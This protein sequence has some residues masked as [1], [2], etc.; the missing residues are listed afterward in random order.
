MS[1]GVAFEKEIKRLGKLDSKEFDTRATTTWLRGRRKKV[2]ARR[3]GL[4]KRLVQTP[5]A[6]RHR[7]LGSC[8]CIKICRLQRGES[9]PLTLGVY[10][11]DGEGGTLIRL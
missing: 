6:A 10:G 4:G 5:L 3:V 8:S 2:R 1:G 11:S 9:T 7:A